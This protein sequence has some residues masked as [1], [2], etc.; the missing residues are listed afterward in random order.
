MV[1]VIDTKNIALFSGGISAFVK[2][3]I[4]AWIESQPNISFVLIGPS[5]KT[6]WIDG[7][8]NFEFKEVTWPTY[9]PRQLR[10]PYYDLILFP[11]AVKKI[12]PDFIYSPYHDVK[13][14]KNV[15]S[16]ITVHDTCIGELR[17]IYPKTIRLYYDKT[18]RRNLK[19]SQN[20][21]TV[22]HASKEAIAKH[23]LISEDRIHIVPN[24]FDL[25]A[26]FK[27]PKTNGVKSDYSDI[28]IFYAGGAE[29]RKNVKNLALSLEV[30]EKRG[31][32][33]SLSVTGNYK[34]AWERE[35]QSI[36]QSTISKFN[37]LGYLSIEK[38]FQEYA[39]ADV[40]AYPSLCE[41]FGRVCL[42]AMALGTPLACSDLPVLREV[43][44]D[45]AHYF[46]PFDVNDIADKILMAKNEGRKPH[47]VKP[48]FTIKYVSTLFVNKMNNFVKI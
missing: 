9:L 32:K 31:Y 1:I 36:S 18:L 42:E 40:I 41:G 33:I 39:N 34:G 17:G 21:I 3:L 8:S 20:I 2:P 12:K 38:L 35:L 4:K 47:T 11:R 30:L 44:G 7:L 43:S 27:I 26:D 19:V 13:L 15:P 16:V 5:M 28:K 45:Y 46:N 23:Y 24:A 25:P 29:F 37:F 6:E 14:P 10:H 22:S 48:E